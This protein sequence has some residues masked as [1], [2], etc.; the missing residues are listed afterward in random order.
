MTDTPPRAKI[1]HH[2][3]PHGGTYVAQLEG[4]S[5]VGKLEWEPRGEDIRIAT[6]TI[7]PPA[8]G[9]RGVAGELVDRMV[10]D[11]RKLGFR[12]VPRCSYV[13]A[14]FDRNPEWSE[15]RAR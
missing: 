5:A 2:V 13:A 6:H 10:E 3:G 14:R 1:T 9:G 11:A 8:I 7:V 12:I 15:L 4:E